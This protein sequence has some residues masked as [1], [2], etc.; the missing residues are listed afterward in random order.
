MR[1]PS[2]GVTRSARWACLAPTVHR[3]GRRCRRTWT[4]RAADLVLRDASVDGH[5][6]PCGGGPSASCQPSTRPYAP[7][8]QRMK[9]LDRAPPSKSSTPTLVTV[10]PVAGGMRWNDPHIDPLDRKPHR[11][12]DDRRTVI[13]SRFSGTCV[14]CGVQW[15]RGALVQPADSGEGWQH[16]SCPKQAKKPAPK[17]A[18][19]PSQRTCP[20]CFE[21][22]S[23]TG[24]C[25]CS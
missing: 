13:H 9:S 18:T 21:V 5:K 20:T 4:E 25:R 16:L 22:P 2:R 17:G 15:K 1:A 24:H 23:A 8:A 12:D 7:G 11:P 3:T 10:L 19:E 14:R 6:G